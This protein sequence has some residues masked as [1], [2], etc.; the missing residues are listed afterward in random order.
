ME[1]IGFSGI[2]EKSGFGRGV[3]VAAV[4]QTVARTIFPAGERS[5]LRWLRESSVL[6]TL[7]NVN[8]DSFNEMT[9]HRAAD[10]LGERKDAIWD[11]LRAALSPLRERRAVYLFDLTDFYLEGQAAGNPKARRGRGKEKRNDCRLAT[12]AVSPPPPSVLDVLP[13]P[14]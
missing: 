2:L 7:M 9:L 1:E 5:T 13:G 14:D 8:F 10:G 4:A 12:L 6:G 3:S 11:G